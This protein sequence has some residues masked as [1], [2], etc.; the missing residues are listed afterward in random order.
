MDRL[1][2]GKDALSGG[3]S[4]LDGLRG[5]EGRGGSFFFFFFL[6]IHLPAQM[7]CL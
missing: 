5:G 7:Y 2:I 6:L 4:V 1:L 3:E